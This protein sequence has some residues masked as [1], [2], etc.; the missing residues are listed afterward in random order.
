[1]HGISTEAT[2]VRIG[3]HLSDMQM[4]DYIDGNFLQEQVEAI[5]E[6]GGYVTTLKR[7]GPGHGE[8]DFDRET[9][10]ED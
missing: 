4:A 1:M 10:G 5:R 9:L 2:S 8:Y 7:V 3:A 6:I